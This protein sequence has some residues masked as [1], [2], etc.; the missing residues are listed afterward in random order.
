MKLLEKIEIV[1]RFEKSTNEPVLLN[2]FIN[3]TSTY[4]KYQFLDENQ[5]LFQEGN[6]SYIH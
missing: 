4:M 3:L 6:L 5:I 2:N 1:K